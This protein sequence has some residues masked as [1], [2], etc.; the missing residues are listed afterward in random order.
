MERKKLEKL[1]QRYMT[2]DEI[3]T[4]F[5]LMDKIQ[6]LKKAKNAVI[7]GHNY[8]TPD[9]YYGV[10]DFTGDSLALAKNAAETDA[11]IIL[12]NGVHFMAETA[13]ILNPHKKV[14]IADLDAGCSLA[15]A[16][17]AEEVL[18][19][20]TENPKIPVVTYINSSASVKAVCDIVCTSANAVKVVESLPEPSVL[21]IPDGYLAMNVQK[22]T[23]K[24]VLYWSGKCM[25][26][27][28]F[29]EM[30]IEMARK[31]F[32]GVKVVAHPECKP[33]VTQISDYTGSTSQIQDYIESEQPSQVL[34][35]TEC[36]M[37]E[38]I[39]GENS[40]V[41]FVSTCQI[42]PHMK[43][44]TLEGVLRS[45]QEEVYEVF[46]EE[47]VRIGAEKSLRRMLDIGR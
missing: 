4:A 21:M 38:N 20:K 14:L 29:S 35:L 30:D 41:E 34:L 39:K 1:L 5:S 16:V 8:M 37:G 26:H 10:S 25:V 40:S 9:V 2:P 43:K 15:E 45:L 27:E 23:E 18:R 33:E 47:K 24:K 11:D 44:I 17:T 13:K 12:F 3:L 36:S 42:C 7:L 32:P 22:K 46:V 6:D 28:L 19:F 31:N